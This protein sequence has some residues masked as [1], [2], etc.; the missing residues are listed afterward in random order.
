MDR[1]I[2]ASASPARLQTLQRAGVAV[3]V[4]VPGV[5]ESAVSA[6]RT[7]DLVASL[8]R[9]KAEAVERSLAG[10]GD[11]A[12]VGC[13]SLL[14]LDGEPIGKP[15]SPDAAASLWRRLRG[16]SG[17]LFTGHHVIVV[18]EGVSWARTATAATVVHF[19]EL[20]D[21]EID[22]YVA[23]GE[24]AE[25]AGAF[26]IDGYGA[27]FV[28]GVEGDHHNVV[29]ISVPLLRDLLAEAGVPWPSLWR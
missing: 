18:R 27:P 29:G 15:G 11:H 22:A 19:A 24:P 3:S 25:V 26:T 21:P 16:R 4:R 1:L 12:L 2:L 7:A 28:R 6:P 23:T 13:D 8:A 10:E 17:T 14:D 20:T 5:D 9:L